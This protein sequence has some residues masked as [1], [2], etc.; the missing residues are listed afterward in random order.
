MADIA[1]GIYIPSYRRAKTAITHK[2]LEYYQYIVRKSEE[3]AYRDAGLENIL[4]VED[5]KICGLTE[6]WQWMFDSTPEEIICIIDDDIEKFYYR[7]DKGE[8]ISDPS[9]ITAEIERIAQIMLDL[10][11]GF[12]ATDPT[13]AP[14]NYT[15]EFEFKGIPGAIKWINKRMFRAKCHKDLEYNLDIDLIFQELITNRVILKP[16]YFCNK[17][18]TDTNKGG[19]SDKQRND[20]VSCIDLMK[21]KWGKYFDYDLKTNKPYIRVER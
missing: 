1:L 10:G 6:V 2:W 15:S 18:G 5:K 12:C 9:I 14:W 7:I 16:K 11:I 20:Q 19:F 13:M 3:E 17:A 21:S 8:Q 4:P